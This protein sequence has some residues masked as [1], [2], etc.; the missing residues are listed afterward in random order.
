MWQECGEDEGQLALRPVH[1]VA[2]YRR[3]ATSLADRGLDP[4]IVSDLTAV[5]I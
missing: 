2:V 3:A 4:C 5:P 1:V